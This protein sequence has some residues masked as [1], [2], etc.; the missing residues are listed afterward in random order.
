MDP[1]VSLKSYFLR[2][3]SVAFV[4]ALVCGVLLSAVAL[5]GW[6]D[7]I[8][9]LIVGVSMFLSIICAVLISTGFPFIFKKAKLDPAVASGPFATMISDITTVTIYFVVASLLLINFGRL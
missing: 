7:P 1:H 8:L 2:E 3:F 4:L 5:V 9:G 6:Q